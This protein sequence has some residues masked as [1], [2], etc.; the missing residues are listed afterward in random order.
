MWSGLNGHFIENFARPQM[1]NTSCD[2][3]G[4]TQALEPRLE[5]ATALIG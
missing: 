2:F 3:Q 4:S 5:R 1:S